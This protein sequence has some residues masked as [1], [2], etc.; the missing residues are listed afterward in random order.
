MDIS[1]N[2]VHVRTRRI[3][4]PVEYPPFFHFAVFK[5]RNEK[6]SKY[7][8][9]KEQGEEDEQSL[10]DESDKN[11]DNRRYSGRRRVPTSRFS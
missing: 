10:N 11:C 1:E 8:E 6:D 7:I 4:K 5:T 2:Q 9:E 3:Q